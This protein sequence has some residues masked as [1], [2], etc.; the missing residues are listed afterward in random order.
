M[1]MSFEDNLTIIDYVCR[2]S[3]FVRGKD[4]TVFYTRQS[5]RRSRVLRQN[6]RRNWISRNKDA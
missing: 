3:V 6:E 1:N 2:H 4:V 5:S